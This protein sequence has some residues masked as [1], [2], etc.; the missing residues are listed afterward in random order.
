M[1]QEHIYFILFSICV[2]GIL[3]FDLTV[4]GRNSH[5]ISFKESIIWTSVWISL[6]LVFYFFIVNYGDRLHGIDSF[7]KLNMLRGK[8]APHLQLDPSSFLNSLEIYRKNM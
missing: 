2:I 8:Y 6:A 5:I 1:T 3:I 7:D 4:V